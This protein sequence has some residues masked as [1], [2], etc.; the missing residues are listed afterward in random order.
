LLAALAAVLSNLT[1]NLVSFDVTPTATATWL[2]LGMGVGLAGPRAPVDVLRQVSITH[3]VWR[4]VTVAVV[5][6]GCGGAIW[7]G[8]LRPLLADVA[9]HA[10]HRH[11]HQGAWDRAAAAQAQALRAWPTAPEYHLQLGQIHYQQALHDPSVAQYRLAQAEAAL[12]TARSLRP[13]DVQVWL[14][15]AHFYTQAATDFGRATHTLADAAYGQ[16]QRLAPNQA[17]IYG[18]RGRLRLAMGDM[19]Q[20]AALLRHAVVLDASHGETYLALGEA[21]WALG[22]E[23]VAVAALREAVR[24]MPRSDVA[25]AALAES[26]WR[27]GRMAEAYAAAAMALKLAPHN[28]Q[29]RAIRQA[30]AHD[31]HD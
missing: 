9:S 24:L 17:G 4:G 8:N 7:L 14:Y 12:L 22:R 27:M 21:E 13:D 16:A 19:A 18:A 15:L 23:A 11:A 26:Y 1:N 31:I 10:A 25:H 28:A 29:A 30:V 20:A 5:A 6:L 2:L 3:P